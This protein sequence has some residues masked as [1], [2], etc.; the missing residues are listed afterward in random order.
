MSVPERMNDHQVCLDDGFAS[1]WE[2]MIAARRFQHRLEV[3]MDQCLD[4]LGMTFAQYRALELID[5]QPEIHVSELARLL[6]ISR[7]GAQATVTKLDRG[8]LIDVVREAGRVYV[9]PSSLGKRQLAHSRRFTEDLKHELE[10]GLTPGELHRLM[11]L[12]EK[13]G[14]SLRSPR[15]PEWW[16]A[17]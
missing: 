11:L 13:A 16:L 7:Q 17:P 12:L 1:G 5:A 15:L 14:R 6:R 9:R 2:V 10:R 3:F 4:H 8:A